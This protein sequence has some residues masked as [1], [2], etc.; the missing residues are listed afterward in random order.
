MGGERCTHQ[1]EKLGRLDNGEALLK[2]DLA[3]EF[4]VTDQGEYLPAFEE[5]VAEV[6]DIDMDLVHNTLQRS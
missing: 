2:R 5:Q 3:P 4:G 1:E 6:V